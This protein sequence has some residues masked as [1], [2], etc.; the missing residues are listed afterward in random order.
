M[1]KSNIFRSKFDPK[2]PSMPISYPI[3]KLEDLESGSYFESFYYP[4]NKASVPIESGYFAAL[5]A[6]TRILVC[7]DM[8]RGYLDDNWV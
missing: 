1:S 8:A 3:D 7:H 4:F 6:R 5:P 2:Q